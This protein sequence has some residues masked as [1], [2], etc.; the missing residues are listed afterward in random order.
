MF[1]SSNNTNYQQLNYIKRAQLYD[2]HEG[3]YYL[4]T[5]KQGFRKG[6][7]VEKNLN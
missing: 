3:T 1:Y 2:K 5:L 6:I 7:C 4:F